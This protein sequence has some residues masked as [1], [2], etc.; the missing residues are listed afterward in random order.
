MP[1]S[2]AEKTRL[3]YDPYPL[4]TLVTRAGVCGYRHNPEPVETAGH[5][6]VAQPCRSPW[7]SL[8]GALSDLV[9]FCAAHSRDTLHIEA[10]V[11]L[12]R[13]AASPHHSANQTALGR[14]S[15]TL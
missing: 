6:P 14:W 13:Q 15:G 9:P 5:A 7:P 3:R 12:L 11:A 4:P 2:P 10:P 8:D 1:V